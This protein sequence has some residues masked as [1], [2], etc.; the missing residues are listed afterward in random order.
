MFVILQE[1]VEGKD[2]SKCKPNTF[3]FQPDNPQGCTECFC[4]D[5]SSQCQQANYVWTQVSYCCILKS[6]APIIENLD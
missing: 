1:N 5:R 6:G 2:C 3:S 4:Y